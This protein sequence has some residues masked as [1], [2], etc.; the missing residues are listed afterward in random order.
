[1]QKII[2]VPNLHLPNARFIEWAKEL[3]NNGPDVVVFE[4]QVLGLDWPE[5]KKEFEAFH[6]VHLERGKELYYLTEGWGMIPVLEA[7]ESSKVSGI[8]SLQPIV[9]LP[10]KAKTHPMY[11]KSANILHLI[12]RTSAA[13]H[14]FIPE[15]G[16]EN[17][18]KKALKHLK[19]MAKSNIGVKTY[20]SPSLFN[21]T[22][23]DEIKNYILYNLGIR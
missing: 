13:V 23:L 12:E 11:D 7:V 10:K 4:K 3:A 15:L 14:L 19:K 20:E 9:A 18:Y 8:F 17:D 16:F 22:E 21:D 2:I 1:M 6:D 5:I